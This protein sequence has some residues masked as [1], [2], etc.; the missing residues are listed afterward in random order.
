MTPK[1][2]L[3]GPFKGHM[4]IKSSPFCLGSSCK[5]S[6]QFIIQDHMAM[7]YKRLQSA[8]ATVDSSMPKSMSTSVK[9]KDQ[10]KRERLSKAVKNQQKEV[11]HYYSTSQMNYSSVSP[12]T[13]RFR[14]KNLMKRPFQDPQKKTYSGD[15]LD[16][17]SNWFT[18]E[19]QSFTPRTLRNKAKSFL[20]KYKYYTAPKNTQGNPSVTPTCNESF[21][22]KSPVPFHLETDCPV[23]YQSQEMRE[24]NPRILQS[25]A[26]VK[27]KLMAWEV[28]MKYLRFLKDVTDDILCRG[29]HS[30]RILENIFQI[31]IERSKYHLNE[32]K[33]KN[34]LQNL[35]H[36]LQTDL[37][38]SSS[39]YRTEAEKTLLLSK[40]SDR[41][42][43]AAGKEL[44]RFK[45]YHKGKRE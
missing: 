28:E 40:T 33:L 20:L 5:L 25:S 14:D 29:Y 27:L 36:E 13:S 30:N 44:N 7:H 42:H 35:R 21:T 12:A 41:T 22:D 11:L 43:R 18:E 32:D 8:K 34:I 2:S 23:W 38:V 4:C 17:H 16:K 31:H 6:T 26:T 39:E 15:L 3:M 19:R 1:H 24:L 10:Q 45:D 9:Y 37:T